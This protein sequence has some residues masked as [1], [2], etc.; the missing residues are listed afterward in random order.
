MMLSSALRW[1]DRL[2]KRQIHPPGKRAS[3]QS[4]FS[5]PD[6]RSDHVKPSFFISLFIILFTEGL[7]LYPLNIRAV[8]AALLGCCPSPRNSALEKEH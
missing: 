3:S 7:Y 8:K 1:Q 6:K 4:C 2:W 5:K